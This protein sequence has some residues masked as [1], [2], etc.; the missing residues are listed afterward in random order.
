[1]MI[2]EKLHSSPMEEVRA[3]SEEI[4]ARFLETGDSAG[5]LASRTSLADAMIAQAHQEFLAPAFPD[6]LALMAVGGYGRRELFPHS[7]VDVLIL[8]EGGPPVG[9]AKEALARFLQTIWD[10]SLRLS[11]SVHTVRDCIEL[12][13]QNIELNVSLLDQRFLT[14]DAALYAELKSKLPRFYQSQKDSLARHLCRLTQERHHKFHATI[15]HLEPNIKEAPGGLRDLHLIGWLGKLTGAQPGEDLASAR[16][17][18]FALRCLLHL[19]SNRDNNLLNFDFQEEF[20]S[21]AFLGVSG[22]APLMRAYFRSARRIHRSALRLMDSVQAKSNSLLANFREWR[23]RLSNAEF[24]VS[25][26]RVL[27]RN[28][29]QLEKDPELALRM[30]HLVA[31]HSVPLHPETERKVQ[32]N[33]PVL[34]KHYGQPRPVWEAVHDIT[35]QSGAAFALRTM[36]E[37]GLLGAIFP[38]WAGVKCYVIRDFNHRYTVDEHTLIA[39]EA[40]DEL[41]RTTDPARQ[42]FA[43]LLSEVDDLA[44]LRLA[45]V[46]HDTGKGE[47]SESHCIES[48]RLAGIAAD[49]IGMPELSR[50]MMLTLI[51]RHLDLSG[52]MNRDLQDPATARWLG[53][54]LETIEVLKSLTLLTYADISAVNPSAMSPWRLD[55]LWRVYRT[56]QKELTRELLT[57]KIVSSTPEREAFLKGLPKRYLRIHTEAEIQQHLRLEEQRRETSLVVDVRKHNGTY[58]L[59]VLAKDR[60]FLFASV[61]G[62]LASFGMNILKAEA[63]CNQQGTVL[64]T[65][66]FSDPQHT[67]ELNPQEIDRLRLTLERVISGRADV[68]SLLKNRPRPSAPSK[69]S[70]IEPSVSIDDEASDSATLIEVVAQDRPGLLNDLSSALSEAGCNIELVLIDTEA[71]KAIDVFY[72][73]A[74]GRKL[75]PAKAETLEARLVAACASS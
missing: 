27:F 31:R 38:E 56:A 13:E 8:V 33:L 3:A 66:A 6:G 1:M 40:L 75:D 9:K 65:F 41:A 43:G 22:P 17:Y 53:E 32:E 12:H 58:H 25:K 14:G 34:S 68:K 63:F 71:H 67:L 44:A 55:Q 10:S 49:R 70:R 37:C 50:R 15:H 4:R 29:Q 74:N 69:G 60:L 39:I 42:R 35:T 18:L 7:D 73:T 2:E 5:A 61:A 46:F 30:F 28:S 19:Q 47:E 21:R 57:E 45:L 16:E 72:V 20:A 36:H 52:A 62:A 54:R 51:E 11:H 24:T 59:T 64:D 23:S 26:D 48:A